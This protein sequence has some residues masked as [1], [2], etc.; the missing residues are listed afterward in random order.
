MIAP[1]KYGKTTLLATLPK[2]MLV[3]DADGGIDSLFKDKQVSA[4]TRKGIYVYP[5][6]TFQDGLDLVQQVWKQGP[7]GK[8]FASMAVDTASWFM[9]GVVKGEILRMSGREKMELQD[10]GLYFERGLKLAK[11]A[12]ELAINPEGC[13]TV[14]TFHEADKGG[15]EGQIGKLGPS[16]QGQ[17][18]DVLPGIPNFVFFMRIRRTGKMVDGPGGKQPEMERVLQTVADHRTPAGSRRELL[19][20]EKPDLTAIWEKVR[21]SATWR[22]GK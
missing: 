14:L 22:E 7:G 20:F 17:L 4:E 21:P 1:G 6:N 5:L 9:G 19:D 8:P 10:W 11:L 15:E 2:P 12:H 18:F 3:G 13:H 16:V